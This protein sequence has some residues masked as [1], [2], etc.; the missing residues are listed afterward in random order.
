M[1]QIDECF[2]HH[3]QGR[4]KEMGLF[5][6]EKGSSEGHITAEGFACSAEPMGWKLPGARILMIQIP[7]DKKYFWK[8][9]R[10]LSLGDFKQDLQSHL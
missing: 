6:S 9:V 8:A 4:W 2:V 1:E 10:V 7:K 5:D 3:G